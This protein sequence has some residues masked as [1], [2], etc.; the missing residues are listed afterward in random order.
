[1]VAFQTPASA[2][3]LHHSP[4]SMNRSR[5][6]QEARRNRAIAFVVFV[7]ACLGLIV[8]TSETASRGAPLLDGEGA[9]ERRL[10]AVAARSAPPTGFRDDKQIVVLLTSTRDPEEC[11]RTIVDAADLARRSDRLH[12]RVY[13][14]ID[15]DLEASCVQMFCD[16]R[17]ALCKEW[18]RD[19]RLVG[20]RRDVSGALGESSAKHIVEGMVDPQAFEGQFYLSVDSGIVFTKNW[21]LTLLK[22]WY[23]A[24][25]DMAI[26]SVAPPAVE[27]HGVV[28]STTFV[29]CSARIHSKDKD[30]VVAFNAPDPR[31]KSDPRS[32]PV[33]QAQYSEHFHFGLVSTLHA[34]RSDPHLTHLA[35]GHEYMRATRFWTKGYDLY[36]P[37]ETALF[38][39][40]QWPL[41]EQEKGHATPESLRSSRRIRRL[42]GLQVSFEKESLL[43]RE[44]YGIGSAR[45]LSTWREFSSIDP[46]AAYNESTTNQFV[47]CGR[48]LHYQHHK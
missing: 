27:T 29:Q 12:F 21:D 7:T 30:A 17:P 33:L 19:E 5:M 3:A 24:G 28:D 47:T 20:S 43:E 37:A 18:L 38:Y 6:D 46:A 41:S 11:A 42:L 10:E 48:T 2:L 31:A 36:A 22:Q 4:R 13:E 34:V 39:R 32:W 8:F 9:R 40:Y 16:L 1:M 35:V 23:S 45:S 25:N 44:V 26:L 15:V 14:E